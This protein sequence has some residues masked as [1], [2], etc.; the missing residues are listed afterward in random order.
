MAY[1][2]AV[3]FPLLFPG[4]IARGANGKLY[5]IVKTKQIKAVCRDESG[6]LWDV[7]MTG[8]K[9]ATPDEK[10][11]FKLHAAKN[12]VADN[13]EPMRLGHV[14]RFKGA[15]AVKFPG[16]YVVIK[17]KG[18]SEVSLVKLG[19]DLQSKYFATVITSNLEHVAEGTFKNV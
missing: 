15:S 17:D 9:E 18:P 11:R 6:Q 14:V 13:P 19:G 7:R 16:L 4:D 8:L 5:E 10:E 3:S 12:G 1:G 2:T